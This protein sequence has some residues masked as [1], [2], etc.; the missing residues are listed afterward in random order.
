MDGNLITTSCVYD[1]AA[2]PAARQDFC[3]RDAVSFESVVNADLVLPVLHV[4]IKEE[5]PYHVHSKRRRCKDP[6][7]PIPR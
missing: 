4:W 1:K 5:A 7:S 2:L 3:I 6:K